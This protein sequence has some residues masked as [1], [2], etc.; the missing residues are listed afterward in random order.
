VA[1]SALVAWLAAGCEGCRSEG[2]GVSGGPEAG[3][4]VAS[5]PPVDFEG[6]VRDKR[7][8]PLPDV[9]IIAWPKG[10]R[11]Q[12]VAQARSGEDGRFLLPGLRPDRWKLL[13]EAGGLGILETE[14]Q[15]PEDGRAVLALDGESRTLTGIVTDGTGRPQAGAR[16]ALG[17]AGLRWT[18]TASSDA[19]G[20]FAVPGL[21][22]GRF[23]LRAVLGQRASAPTVVVFEGASLRPT[24]VR[25]TLQPGIFVEGRVVDDTGKPLVD[26]TVDVMAMPSDDLPMSARSGRDGRF[27]L[28][29]VAPGK[30][31]VLARLDDYVLLDAPEP[32]LGA[33]PTESFELRLA[34]TARVSGRVLDESGQPM[35]G[36]LVYSICLIG[37]RDDLVVI[38]GPLPLAAEAAGLPVGTLLRPGGVRSGPTDKTGR[39]SLTGLAPGRTRI[40]ILH[41]DKLPLRREPLLLA[42]G[43]VRDLGDL[44][45]LTGAAL[46]GK[47]V[48]EQERPVEGAVVEAKLA[49]RTA[50]YPVRATTDANGQFFLRVPRGDYVLSAQTEKLVL[51]APQAVSLRRNAATELRILKLAPRANSRR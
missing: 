49:G 26:A 1:V 36:L 43:D 40:E 41:P 4:R 39:F 19:N 45:M 37:G 20:I 42:P 11:G 46:T 27:R 18:R 14:R 50:H 22:S 17:G 12:A 28:G 3:A 47:V 35:V 38:P 23:T 31:Q 30:H 9:L 44:T 33:R 24:H 48:D 21:G 6:V 51:A 5:R 8:V 15:V 13:V 32:R 2:E 29:P 7:G 10:K 34:R 25:L 16:V